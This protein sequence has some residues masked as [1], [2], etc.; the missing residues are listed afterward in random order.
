M[1]SDGNMVR[2]ER[3]VAMIVAMLILFVI[4]VLA[5]MLTMTSVTHSRLSGV[6]Q[7]RAKALDLAEA[8]ISEVGIH[9]GLRKG[10]LED[11]L[12]VCELDLRWA[13]TLQLGEEGIG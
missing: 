5:A 7:R 9:F 11:A 2:N 3:G 10:P 13:M 8:G 12:A 4:G 6:E 1:R